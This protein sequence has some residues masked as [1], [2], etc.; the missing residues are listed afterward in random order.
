MISRSSDD[1]ALCTASPETYLKFKPRVRTKDF[2]L[3]YVNT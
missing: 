3:G 1:L 2:G